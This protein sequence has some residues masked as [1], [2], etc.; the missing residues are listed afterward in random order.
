MI[1]RFLLPLLFLTFSFVASANEVALDNE[2]IPADRASVLRGAEHVVNSCVA[3]HSLKYIKY[4]DLLEL[5]IASK[6]VD[7]WRG[8]NPLNSPLAAQMPAEVAAA[9]FG[10]IAPPDLSL[11]AIAR[12]GG[13]HYLYSYMLGFTADAGGETTNRIYPGT[14]M[15][16]VLGIATATDARQRAEIS[17]KAKEIAAFLTWAADPHADER[18]KLG[19][20]VIAYLVFMTALLYLWK[21]QIW[22]RLNQE[23]NA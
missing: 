15:P 11:T 4:S 12:A 13:A 6:T 19:W 17:V 2:K 16:D 21:R 9:A 18:K 22:S 8:A 10:G 3:C 20:Y 23:K 7:E 14:R 5:G 1:K